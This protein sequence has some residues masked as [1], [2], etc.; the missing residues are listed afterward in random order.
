[1]RLNRNRPINVSLILISFLIFPL[2]V[3]PTLSLQSSY[4]VS[5]RGYVLYN[6]KPPLLRGWG[7]SRIHEADRYKGEWTDG[8]RQEPASEVFPFEVA[9]DLEMTVKLLLKRGYNAI[10]VGFDGPVNWS[11]SKAGPEWQWNEA[12]F[13]KALEICRHYGIWMIICYFGHGSD[14]YQH[15]TEWLNF[16]RYIIE[17][18]GPRYDKIV[19]EP[20]N[21]PLPWYSDGSNKLSGRDAV[22]LIGQIYQEWINMA[23]GLGDAH[24]LVVPVPDWWNPLPEEEWWPNVT[25]PLNRTFLGRHHYFFYED[26]KNNWTLEAAEAQ[27]DHDFQVDMAAITRY[28]KPFLNTEFGATTGGSEAPDQVYVNGYT[29]YSNTTLAYVK[30]LIKNYEDAGL[31][32]ILFPCSDVYPPRLYGDMNVWGQYVL[33]AS[34][35]QS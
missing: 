8:P 30:R 14:P 35:S 19:W 20:C 4:S 9:S 29:A 7:A 1:M 3:S 16:W 34:G 11:E 28:G 24:W 27:A 17:T 22:N 2:A 15:T 25:D 10:R 23:R 26:H 31:G 12:Y 33:N 32:Y 6:S 21:E 13:A 18:Y 5:S